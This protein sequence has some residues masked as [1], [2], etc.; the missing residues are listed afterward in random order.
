MAALI[1]PIALLAWTLAYRRHAPWRLAFLE[2]LVTAGAITLLITEVLSP[3]Y[4]IDRTAVLICWCVVSMIPLW[5]SVR[6]PRLAAVR[7]PSLFVLVCVAVITV[8]AGLIAATAI[9]SP[10]NS[11]DAMS[12]HLPRVVYWMQH[13]SVAFF[14]TQYLNQIMLQ[15]LTEYIMLHA[16]LLAGSDRF[17]NLVQFA[18]YVGSIAGV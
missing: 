2:A 13:R 16:Y 18:G 4:A 1:Q 17:T 15:P 7:R 11:A 14:P 12:Y 5:W 9:L 3:W 6:A 10:P 8:M